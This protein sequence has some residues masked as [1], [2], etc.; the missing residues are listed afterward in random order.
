VQDNHA[1]GLWHLQTA[2]ELRSLTEELRLDAQ[3]GAAL[4]G[5]EVAWSRGDCTVRYRVDP[6][7]VLRR[8]APEACGGSRGL[9]TNVDQL[10]RVVGGV[11][12]EFA[13]RLRPTNEQHTTVFIPLGTP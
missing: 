12:I 6:R 1:L 4:E 5:E 7:R 13:R 8:E 10:R 11:E 9:A 3:S 2:D